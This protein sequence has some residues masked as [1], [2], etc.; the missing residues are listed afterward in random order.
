ML[1][2]TSDQRLLFATTFEALLVRAYSDRITPPLK[3]Q[4]AAD[5]V[6]LDHPFLPAFPLGTWLKVLRTLCDA[7]RRLIAGVLA[8]ARGGAPGCVDEA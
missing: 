3:R 7:G 2:A 8:T 6:D 5:G 1:A 4:L